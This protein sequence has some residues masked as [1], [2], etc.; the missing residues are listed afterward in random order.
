MR[1]RPFTRLKHYGRKIWP[2]GSKPALE[3][4]ISYTVVGLVAVCLLLVAMSFPPGRIYLYA[5]LRDPNFD[6]K[7]MFVITLGISLL[8]G[9][10]SLGYILWGA[11]RWFSRRAKQFSR[12]AYRSLS[13]IRTK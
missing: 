10:F 4:V 13:T 11:G 9:S 5:G 12:H 8:A 6:N 3:Q 7:V 2:I 1:L